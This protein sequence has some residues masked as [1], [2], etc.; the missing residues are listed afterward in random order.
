MTYDSQFRTIL[1][2]KIREDYAGRLEQVGRGSALTFEDYK[3]NVGWLRGL[4]HVLGLCQDTQKEMTE[5]GR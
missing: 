2:R 1:E 5:E 4:E 3:E